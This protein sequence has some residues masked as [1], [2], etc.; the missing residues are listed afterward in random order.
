MNGQTRKPENMVLFHAGQSGNAKNCIYPY[1]VSITSIDSLRQAVSSDYVCARYRN[2]YRSTGNFENAN[3]AGAD[4]DNEHSEN[5]DD[6]ITPNDVAKAFPD[7]IYAIHYSRHHMKPKGGK[8]PRP[9]FH[10]LFAIDMVHDA[11]IYIGL[12]KRLHEYFP[13]LDTQAMD[14][15]RF[16]FGTVDP[17]VT[18][19]QGIR[20]LTDFLEER[21]DAQTSEE[22]F[23]RLCENERSIPQGS[24][25]STMSRFAARVLKRYGVTETAH[26]LFLKQADRCDP[27]LEDEELNT[28]WQSA[29]RFYSRISQ[30]DDYVPPEQYNAGD[31]VYKP[32]DCTDVGQARALRKFFDSELRY[33]PATDYIRYN[34]TYWQETKPGAQAVVHAL[35]DLQLE[36]ARQAIQDRAVAYEATGAAEILAKHPKKKAVTLLNDEQLAAYDLYAEASSYMSFALQRRE[37][38][39]ITATLHE[40][41]PELEIEPAKLDKDWF[42]LCTPDATYDLRHGLAGAKPHNPEDFITRVTSASPG[43]KGR[44]IWLAALKVFFNHDLELMKY[45]QRVAGVACVGQVFWEAMII[46]YG[47]GRN[48]KS[49]FWN[50]LARV[51]GLYSGNISADSLTVGC[52]RNVKPEMAETRGKRL[53]IAAELEEGTR[54]NTSTVKQLTSTDNV[55]AEKKYKDPFSFTPSHTLVLYTNHLPKVGALDTGIWRRLVVI[56]FTA[57]IEG[58][59]DIKNYADHLVQNAGEAIMA[60]MIEGA[61]EAIE[62]GFKIPS[63]DCVKRA[64]DEYR[65][66]NDWLTHFLNDRCEI[67]GGLRVKSGDLYNAYRTYCGET[68]EYIRSTTDFYSALEG[69]GF[70]R[71]RTRVANVI[72]GLNLRASEFHQAENEFP[73][74]LQ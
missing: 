42:L 40:A 7:V 23:Q 53:L 15:A 74:F 9:K 72:I 41:R 22:D 51:L 63:P 28:I 12:L 45:V 3:T 30:Q 11:D 21:F 44:D 26:N 52:R 24:R 10:I 5:P 36:E 18:L 33:S 17:Q 55:F 65:E 20:T 4:C 59:S 6:W 25:N 68:N 60:W 58:T 38:K 16:F 14:A 73:D 34:G 62:L 71:Q 32:D 48:G 50:A 56:P 64:I 35:T 43:N 1:A 47:D 31:F 70:E 29:S 49:T 57:K 8:A 69:E 37:S 67:G 39:Y 54:L 27:P 19:H 66:Q 61:K 13:Y 2:N 46:A